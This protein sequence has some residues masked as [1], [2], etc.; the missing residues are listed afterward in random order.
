LRANKDA[1]G[2]HVTDNQEGKLLE[3]SNALQRRIDSWA[4]M[5]ELYMPNMA[6]MRISDNA[7]AASTSSIPSAESFK[8]WLPSQIG[9]S[10]P[11]DKS[12]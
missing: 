8:L 1:R 5:Q 2:L 4:K 11:C 3:R 7:T 9:R 12:L 10:S 6:A